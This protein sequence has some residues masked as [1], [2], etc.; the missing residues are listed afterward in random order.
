MVVGSLAAAA[1]LSEIRAT[2]SEVPVVDVGSSLAPSPEA[3]EPRNVLIIGTDS[4]S[5]LGDDDP[6]T[7]GR[8][9]MGQL[10]DVIMI[11]R[12]DPRDGTARLLSI[13]RDS[14]VAVA[15]SGRMDR[16]N[17]A[18]AAGGAAGARN[19]VQTVKRNFGIPID[20]YVEVD[21]KSFRDLVDVLDGVPVHFA[22][23]VRDRESGLL[24][25]EPGCV[26]LD[27]EQALAYARAR[28]FQYRTEDGW[29]FDTS[30][31]LG[32]ITRQQDFIKRAIQRASDQG[33]RNPATAN[34]VV[35]AAASSVTMDDTLDVGTILGLAREFR[36]FNA[37]TL[38]SSQ[39]P[40]VS[41]PRG[42]VAYQ[43]VLWDEAEAY[44]EPFRGVDPGAAITPRNVIV[45][46]TEEQTPLD[47]LRS[48]SGQLD[49]A[50]FDAEVAEGGS[51][52]SR[53]TITFGPRGR[54]AALVLAAQLEALPELE[55]DDEIT[56]Y[57]V[58]LDIGGDFAGVR[59][60]PLPLDQLPPDLAPPTSSSTTIDPTDPSTTSSTDTTVDPAD[61][62]APPEDPVDVDEAPG[63]VPTDPE[64]AALCR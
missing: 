6:V 18:I 41:D 7:D 49:A 28:N 19:L 39:I 29:E 42:G 13:P 55:L 4:A 11:L 54:D 48:V 1:A 26:M 30:G 58:E 22:V 53:T 44:L 21:F 12:V 43:R 33:I 32:R 63:V 38:V 52:G 27:P 45:D 50:G 20:N 3:T 46:V 5:R 62:N 57:R 51:G 31:D 8:E 60:E 2:I 15:P 56:G 23:P 59:A 61:P 10:A 64:R 37:E 24:V 14:R 17:T 47:E 35:N 36:S 16:I 9:L 25:E 40:T 34:G